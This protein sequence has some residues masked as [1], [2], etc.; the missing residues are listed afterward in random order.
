[1][2]TEPRASVLVPAHQEQAVI[3]RCLEHL[4]RDASEDEFDVVVVAN[5]CTDG[6]ATAAAD[7]ARRLGVRVRVL[8]CPT[9]S[10]SAALERAESVATSWPRVYLDADVL[11]TTRSLHLLL[12]AAEAPG[13]EL[14]VPQR[15]LDLA[16]ASRVAR[17]YYRTWEDL[18][19]VRDQLAGRGCYVLTQ[20]G[21]ERIGPL[22]GR[23]ADDLFV[24]S[25]IPRER[26]VIAAAQ[27][28]VSPPTRVGDIV[29]VRARVF[30]ANAALGP[31]AHPAPAAG[32]CSAL[33]RLA[34]HPSACPGLVVYVVV[35]VVAKAMAWGRGVDRAVARGR[36][37]RR[38]GAA[39]TT[40]SAA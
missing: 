15:H 35:T 32:R 14:V 22:G 2:P 6:T 9:A 36:D 29:R 37:G 26:A 16:S 20:C 8:E 28:R 10:K 21:R 23:V 27:V 17:R 12:D 4:L 19:W 40:E 31:L 34:A 24:T 11:C 33:L 7:T 30:A 38:G 18:P 13:V 5:G 3:G 39:V 25:S 1:M